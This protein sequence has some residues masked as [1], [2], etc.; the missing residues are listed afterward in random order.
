LIALVVAIV[1][2]RLFANLLPFRERPMFTSDI[3]YRAPLYQIGL[4]FESWSSFPSD[5]AALVF[6]MSTGF[7]LVSRW[8]GLV[9]FCFAT[10]SMAAR[11]YFGLHYPS[12]VLAGALIGISVTLAINNSFMRANVALPIVAL[13]QRAPGI[14]YG[15]LFPFLYEVSW[16]FTFTRGLRHAILHLLYGF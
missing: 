7:W 9:W 6:V 1:A 3:G 4:Y 8:W 2:A 11:I 12:D 15:L 16:L 10:A 5:T 13:A 14:F